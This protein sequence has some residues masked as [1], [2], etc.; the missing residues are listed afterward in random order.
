MLRSDA[1]QDDLQTALTASEEDSR[2]RVESIFADLGSR[3]IDFFVT[4][5]FDRNQIELVR[6][7]DMR[8]NGQEH[9]VR[10]RV[11]EDEID[12]AALDERFHA[13]HEKAY[14][15]RLPSGVE[16]VNYHVS[17][18]V[19]TAKPALAELQPGSGSPKLKNTRLVDFDIW[20]RLDSAVYERSELF[21]GCQ[22]HG[23]AIIEEVA[24]S[25]VVPPGVRVTVDTIGNLVMTI[26]D[27]A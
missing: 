23:P 25:T 1:M 21:P 5:G 9:T 2:E 17:A 18:V 6:S 14:T 20:G 19:P 27:E 26:G 10:V 15:F 11:V 24:A 16:I 4:A 8:Y 22:L 12:F 13:A 7:L 3:A